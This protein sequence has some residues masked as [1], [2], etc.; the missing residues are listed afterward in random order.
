MDEQYRRIQ[1][2]STA[3]KSA[4]A[5]AALEI[6]IAEHPEHAAAHNDLGVLCYREGL[7]NQSLREYQVATRL[8]PENA[9]YQKNLADYLFV[10]EGKAEEALQIYVQL[11]KAQPRDPETLFGLGRMCQL[12]GRAADAKHFYEKTLELE[13]WNDAARKGLGTFTA[14]PPTRSEA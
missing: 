9:T 6:F 12:L 11:L 7:K 2:L 14:Q 13:P 10:E 1:E 4:D 5:I 8:D 3:G